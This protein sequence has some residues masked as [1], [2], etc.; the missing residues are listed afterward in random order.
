MLANIQRPESKKS[1]C[2]E[3][4]IVQLAGLFTVAALKG[5]VDHWTGSSSNGSALFLCCLSLSVGGLGRWA[6]LQVF[7]QVFLQPFPLAE[8]LP[9]SP[10]HK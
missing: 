9:L 1:Q 8:R 4:F 5:H 2:S 10:E 7:I 3:V 6:G